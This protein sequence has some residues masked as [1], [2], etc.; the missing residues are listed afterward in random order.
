MKV[1]I[2][3]GS[4]TKS[5]EKVFKKRT[6]AEKFVDKNGNHIYHWEVYEVE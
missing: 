6:D 1:Y 2:V 5:I 4:W 3:W